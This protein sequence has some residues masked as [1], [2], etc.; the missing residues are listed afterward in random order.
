LSASRNAQHAQL[1]HGIGEGRTPLILLANKAC[2]LLADSGVLLS[3]V[4][5]GVETGDTRGWCVSLGVVVDVPLTGRGVLR[6]VE[7]DAVGGL[8]ESCARSVCTY[9]SR[10]LARRKAFINEEL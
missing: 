1:S 9:E 3:E 8:V 7:G 10:K 2:K 4:D 6:S 5:V